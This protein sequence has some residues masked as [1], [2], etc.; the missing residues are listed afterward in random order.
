MR[1]LTAHG[2]SKPLSDVDAALLRRVYDNVCQEWS[3]TA[4][5]TIVEANKYIGALLSEAKQAHK[6]SS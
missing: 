6:D 4:N 3:I 1:D 2:W 5:I